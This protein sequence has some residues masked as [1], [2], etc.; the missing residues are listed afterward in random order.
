MTKSAVA[1]IVRRAFECGQAIYPV[2]G[3]TSLDYGLPR[4]KPGIALSL[5]ALNR[6]VDYPADDLT[7]TVQSGVTLN[8]LNRRLAEKRQWLPIDVP[9]P[10]KAT[11]GGV[12]ATNASGPRR[13]S[14]GTIGDYLI[15]FRAIDGRGAAY[16]GG[17]KVVKNVAGYNLPR[18]I[19]GALGTLGVITEATL[20]VRPLP[21]SSALIVCDAP[22]FGQ[23]ESLLDGLGHSQA[24][25]TVIELIVGPARS[26]CPVPAMPGNA[27][28]RLIVGFEG[29]LI[30]VQAMQR[31]LCD[32]WNRVAP[33]AVT[34]IAGAGVASILDWLSGCPALMQI[35]V[36]PSRTVGLMEQIA[37][38]IPD[39]PLQAHAT[40]GVIKV[41][42]PTNSEGLSNQFFEIVQ[43][44]LRPLVATSSWTPDDFNTFDAG[45]RSKRHLGRHVGVLAS[46]RAEL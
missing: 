33:A 28:A 43:G 46:G 41:Y 3:G 20:M 18:L 2:G 34:T 21:E 38:Q 27:T 19:V 11:I 5:A 36:L 9:D 26:G 42:P 44:T 8:E 23:A 30:D 12:I 25:P 10:N 17:G 29:S 16:C 4:T 22:S 32:E 13:H 24:M 35:N 7:V 14:Y 1:S 31:T 45:I 6:V 37:A 40:S 15:G 39:Y